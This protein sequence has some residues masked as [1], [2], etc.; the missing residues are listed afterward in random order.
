M[1]GLGMGGPWAA[2][3][4]CDVIRSS[5]AACSG[6][7]VVLRRDVVL[8]PGA[9]RGLGSG[10]LDGLG[11]R[12]EGGLLAGPGVGGPSSAGTDLGGGGSSWT[13]CSLDNGDWKPRGAVGPDLVRLWL[14]AGLAGVVVLDAGGVWVGESDASAATPMRG[15]LWAGSLDAVCIDGAF[16]HGMP[17]LGGDAVGATLRSWRGVSE[18]LAWRGGVLPSRLSALIAVG[19]PTRGA[20]ASSLSKVDMRW[21]VALWRGAGCVGP[22]VVD[23]DDVG[24]NATMRA[25]S[26]GPNR[27]PGWDMG[28]EE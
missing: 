19:D 11:R 12:V 10:V 8:S 28:P 18:V 24:A 1:A 16:G 7:H 21:G 17:L 26:V 6:L 9:V 27:C 3:P 2:G 15:W 14:T 23:G 25:D 4:A 22:V 20:G 5:C 13:V